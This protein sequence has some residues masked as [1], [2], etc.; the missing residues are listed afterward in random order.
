MS[1]TFYH[2]GNNMPYNT[3]L[4]E[5]EIILSLIFFQDLFEV[6]GARRLY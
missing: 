6:I 1:S 4:E 5:R 2:S 3:I